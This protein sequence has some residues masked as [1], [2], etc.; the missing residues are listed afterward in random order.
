MK[1]TI[2][3]LLC[4]LGVLVGA[5][6]GIAE[7]NTRLISAA[8]PD[9]S[10]SEANRNQEDL[11]QYRLVLNNDSPFFSASDHSALYLG[12]LNGGLGDLPVV[13]AQFSV[14]DLD[15]DRQD[16]VIVKLSVNG[17]EYGY[18]VLDHRDGTV[19]GYELVYRSMLDLKADGT[20]SFASSASDA[21]F[22]TLKWMND[23][24]RIQP[25]AY[26]EL[27]GDGKVYYYH[28]GK[29]IP[30]ELYD[31]LQNTQDRKT[32]V[33]WYD[34]TDENIEKVFGSR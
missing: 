2:F 13:F 30:G 29:V 20:F 15:A 23:E 5:S 3:S 17:N 6:Y 24:Y 7:T 26:S 1:R 12:Q 16:E 32:A 19:Y 14:A 28:D 8:S 11:K 9:I 31:Q 27:A 21:G 25:I 18:E 10:A 22:G 33:T 34:F 4:L